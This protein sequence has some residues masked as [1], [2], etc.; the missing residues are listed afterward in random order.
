MTFTKLHVSMLRVISLAVLTQAGIAACAIDRSI[1]VAE[2]ERHGAIR[3]IDGS[4]EIARGGHADSVRMIDGD[5][6][7]SEESSVERRVRITDGVLTMLP[8]A[9][10]GGGLIAHHAD[11]DLDGATIRGNV[12][13]FCTGGRIEN[14]RIEGELRVRETA[15]WHVECEPIKDLVV[16]P[17]TEI[18]RLSIESSD[19]EV[20]VS[21]Q[22]KIG[23]VSGVSS[24]PVER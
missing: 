2:G 5:V 6:R 9:S 15:L 11:L 22:A 8:G 24:P 12:E 23:E 7:L 21:K 17:G 1:V 14:T 13:I 4:I 20:V 3:V 10:I 19:V 18:D 16:G